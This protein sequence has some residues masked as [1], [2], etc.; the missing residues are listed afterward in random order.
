MFCVLS[1]AVAR[2][3]LP[4]ELRPSS[5]FALAMAVAQEVSPEPH[6]TPGDEETTGEAVIVPGKE[7]LL[8]EMLGRGE[9]LAGECAFTGGQTERTFIR[10][11]YK[12]AAGEVVIE[13]RHPN[14][15]T[16]PVAKTSAFAIIVLSGTPPPALVTDLAARI[17]SRE[18]GFAWKF[19]APPAKK[20][21]RSSLLAAALVL[22]AIAALGW[23]VQRRRRHSAS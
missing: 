11:T 14:W 6:T 12:C 20:L 7:E 10:G 22:V 13:L 1:T 17:R 15:A 19:L 18:A 9:T 5:P 8:A 2:L 23:A 21:S 4:P 16:A 3:A